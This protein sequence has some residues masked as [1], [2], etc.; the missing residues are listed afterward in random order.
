MEKEKVV[1]VGK[2]SL[3]KVTYDNDSLRT[4]FDVENNNDY[5]IVSLV[6]F[7]NNHNNTALIHLDIRGIT[8]GDNHDVIKALTTLSEASEDTL[9]FLVKVKDYLTK[10]G[11]TVV[12]QNDML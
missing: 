3:I 8:H 5:D 4:M 2:F 1:S 7:V 11:Y 10:D 9:K 12:Y 6:I